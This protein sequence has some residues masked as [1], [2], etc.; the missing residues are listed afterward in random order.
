MSCWIFIKQLYVPVWII[1]VSYGHQLSVIVDGVSFYTFKLFR[2]VST[3]WKII[4]VPFLIVNGLMPLTWHHWLSEGSEGILYRHL[5]LL[6]MLLI[7]VKGCLIWVY[8]N[9]LSLWNILALCTSRGLYISHQTHGAVQFQ[10]MFN[11]PYSKDI[12]C[13][14]QATGEARSFSLLLH[15]HKLRIYCRRT[16]NISLCLGK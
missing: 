16:G 1:V 11:M 2:D 14:C 13:I 6:I 7:M 5:K 10:F 9:N 4:Y 15:V 3:V 8:A 12:H